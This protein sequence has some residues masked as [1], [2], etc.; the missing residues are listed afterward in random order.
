VNGAA[1]G[2]ER[3]AGRRTGT[4]QMSTPSAPDERAKRARLRGNVGYGVVLGLV[5]A[6]ITIQLLTTGSSGVRLLTVALQAATLVAV[7]WTAGGR[8]PVVRL[9]TAAAA[10]VMLAAGVLW[11]IH[12]SV[13][14]GAAGIVNGLLV[15]VAPPALAASIVRAVRADGAVTIR[16]VAGVLA[17]YLLA[18]M[19]FSFLYGVIGAFDADAVFAESARSTGSNDLYFSFVTLATVGYGDLTPGSELART[20]AVA[21]MLFGQIYLVTVVAVMVSNL[22]RRREP[23]TPPSR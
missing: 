17:I 22:G 15:A 18:G 9:A 2:Q 8:R 14:P 3:R 5:T 20:F 11:L 23:V 6:S 7:T 21:E 10:L 16:T 12:G 19:F 4:H 1:R 13:P